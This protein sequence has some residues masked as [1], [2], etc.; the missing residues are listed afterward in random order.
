MKVFIERRFK[1]TEN[2]STLRQELIAGLT[3]FLT[4]SYI[5]FVNPAILSAAGMDHGSVYVATCLVTIFSCLLAGLMSNYPI[6]IAPAMGLNVF[7]TYTVVQTLGYSWQSALGIVF[8]AGVI[9]FLLALTRIRQ[10]IIELMPEALN[11]GTAVGIGLFITLIALQ[12]GGIIVKSTGSALIRVGDI[13]AVSSL[14]FFLGFLII[15]VLDFFKIRGAIII[16]ILCITGVSLLLGKT[17]FQG[18]FSMPPSIK[19]TLLA[20]NLHDLL[21]LS[22]LSILFA[23]ILVGFFDATGTLVGVLR[24]PLF[25]NDPQR[26]KRLSR[27]LIADSIG[28][29]AGSLLGTASTSTYIESAAGIEAGGRTG[30]TAITVSLLFILAL[31]ISP[32]AQSVPAYAVAPAL[33]YVGLLMLRNLAHLPVDDP[34]EFI[35][36]IIIV[37]MIPFTFS[38]ADGLGMGIISYVLLKIFTGK[39]KQLNAMLCGLAL[40]FFIYFAY[41]L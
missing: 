6:V 5:I 20:I 14:L 25:R 7:F 34:I 39:L 26:S 4:M 18:V 23:F 41:R 21:R 13:T 3:T 33:I 22:N 8:I 27:A 30:L 36:A 10:W 29:T 28:A 37:V 31:F 15:A 24:Q 12:N 40:I 19:P 35:P 9:F 11:S 38:I 1:I 16:S 17:H 32:L 2:H